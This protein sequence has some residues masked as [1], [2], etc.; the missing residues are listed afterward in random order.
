M[1]FPKNLKGYKA[2]PDG[3]ISLKGTSWNPVVGARA[4]VLS[5]GPRGRTFLLDIHYRAHP[6]VDTALELVHPGGKPLDLDGI[7]GGHDSRRCQAGCRW[8]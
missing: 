4:K 8:D 1:V 6:G 2:V 7:T 5:P 3:L